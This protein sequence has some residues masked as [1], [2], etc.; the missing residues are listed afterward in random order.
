MGCCMIKR[1]E[2]T[3]LTSGERNK[4]ILYFTYYNFKILAM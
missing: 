4:N 1:D 3:G 2:N